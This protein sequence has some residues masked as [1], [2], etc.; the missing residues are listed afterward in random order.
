MKKIIVFLICMS[1]ML[2]GCTNSKT[3][4]ETRKNETSGDQNTSKEETI[5][6]HQIE[7]DI[8]GLTMMINSFSKKKAEI[9]INN[10][11]K[12]DWDYGEKFELEYYN[13]ERR[14]WMP[15]NIIP[16]YAG[17]KDI[18]YMVKAGETVNITVEW[19]WLYGTLEK[20][21]YRIVKELKPSPPLSSARA[22]TYT[23]EFEIL[24]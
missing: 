10:Q 13:V 7:N 14:A 23:T 21:K 1:I 5:R 4:N 8:E 19:E 11:T 15:V 2:I 22:C 12:L 16:E 6:E 24:N 9:C 18:A 3:I 20:G 17:V